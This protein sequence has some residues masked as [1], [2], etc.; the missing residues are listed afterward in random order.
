MVFLFLNIC[1]L[2]PYKRIYMAT[3]GHMTC[4]LPMGAAY[5]PPLLGHVTCFGGGMW[6]EC[7][8]P[9]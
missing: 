7:P 3:C 6:T 4:S 9:V 8:M 1:F 5:C 2:L